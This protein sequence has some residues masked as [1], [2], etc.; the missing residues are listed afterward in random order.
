VSKSGYK[1]RVAFQGEHGAFSEEAATKLLGPE[2]ELVPRS[3]FVALFSSLDEGLANF[4]L[5]PI[6]NSLIG[7]IEAAR[8]LL[9][10]S[11]LVISGEVTI[12]VEQHLIGCPGVLF[13]EIEAV[14]SHPAALAQCKRFFA[15]HPRIKR[16]ETEDTAG[17]VARIIARGDLKRAAIAGRRAAEIYGG[18]IIREHLEDSPENYTRF[19]L[20]SGGRQSFDTSG[21]GLSLTPCFSNLSEK[22]S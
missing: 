17:S 12:K 14:E 15:E 20:L 9:G 22:S 2:I 21:S 5:A 7:G 19:V 10:E 13:E 3:T 4:I 8:N 1:P 16:I 11:T 6:E 18:T